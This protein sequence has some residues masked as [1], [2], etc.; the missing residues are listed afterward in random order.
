VPTSAATSPLWGFGGRGSTPTDPSNPWANI[1]NFA[2]SRS[3]NNSWLTPRPP[4]PEPPPFS[5]PDYAMRLRPA[6]AAGLSSIPLGTTLQDELARQ[7]AL[8]G[9]MDPALADA[10][11]RVPALQDI[12]DAFTLADSL[13]S[14]RNDINITTAS[15]T[16]AVPQAPSTLSGVI[17][18]AAQGASIGSVGGPVGAG[19]GAAAGALGGLL[20]AEGARSAARTTRNR[21]ASRGAHALATTEP[22]AIGGTLAGLAPSQRELALSGGYGQQQAQAL[23]EAISRSGLRDSAL[24]SLGGLAAA[25]APEQLARAQALSQ[26]LAT[27]RRNVEAIMG[28]P[29]RPGTDRLTQALG[30][31]TEGF[32]TYKS[33]FP[34]TPKTTSTSTSSS[35]LTPLPEPPYT[36]VDEPIYTPAGGWAG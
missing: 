31:V 8:R 5:V 32:L 9:P 18:G 13:A 22:G 16:S 20:S 29:V 6:L 17:G 7:I 3:A 27:T 2:G 14:V 1:G 24:G 12:N 34:A 11:S 26:T 28:Q 30:A 25:A 33:L 23:E 21:I 19:V 4:P 36:P 35:A 10:V 15:G